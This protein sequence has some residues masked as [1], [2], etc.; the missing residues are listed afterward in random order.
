MVERIITPDFAPPVQDSAAY[1]RQL[2]PDI[3]FPSNI[4]DLSP[5]ILSVL[6]D[7]KTVL[8]AQYTDRA[9][10][11]T[12]LLGPG[13]VFTTHV[14]F[15]LNTLVIIGLTPADFFAL[16][17]G[18]ALGE[19][20]PIA[21]GVPLVLPISKFVDRGVDISVQDV[22]TPGATNWTAYILASESD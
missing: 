20:G 6:K 19:G 4:H 15:K 22:T 21:A 5:D 16:K 3:P 17:V 13:I 10:P 7:I 8:N 9:R 18:T 11:S 2:N 12:I 14:R 1:G